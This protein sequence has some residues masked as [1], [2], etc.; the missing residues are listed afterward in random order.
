M[1]WPGT[2]DVKWAGLEQTATHLFLSLKFWGYAQLLISKVICYTS[3]L[4]TQKS[5][6]DMGTWK[7]KPQRW[8]LNTVCGSCGEDRAISEGSPGWEQM[9]VLLEARESELIAVKRSGKKKKP[10][11]YYWLPNFP[12]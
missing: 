4:T 11:S 2:P 12:C 5:V 10:P 8:L 1:C 9:P 7:F 6:A 3:V